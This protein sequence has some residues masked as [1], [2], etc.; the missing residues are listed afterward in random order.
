[1]NAMAEAEAKELL[2]SIPGG[3]EAEVG[4]RGRKLPAD[5]SNAS[6]SPGSH[7]KM[8]RYWRWMK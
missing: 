2:T 3:L 4:E 5:R 6:R 7:Q 1:V 8:L